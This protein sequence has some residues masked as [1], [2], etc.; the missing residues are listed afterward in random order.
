MPNLFCRFDFSAIIEHISISFSAREAQMFEFQPLTCPIAHFASAKTDTNRRRRPQAIAHRG[1]NAKFPENTLLAFS[2]AV[3][4]NADALE[5]DVHL[6]KDGVVVL[7]HV[8]SCFS[9]RP[10]LVKGPNI[11][12]DPDLK[13]TLG[14]DKQIKQCD[15]EYLKGLKTRREPHEPLARLEDLLKLFRDPG[16]EHI[17]LLLDIKVSKVCREKHGRA[18]LNR[19]QIDDDPPKLMSAVAGVFRRVELGNGRRWQDRVVL[20]YWSVGS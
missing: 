8:S 2:E 3:R 18:K 15:W 6:S 14:V 4:A 16:W 9:E 17:W 1:F 20:A 10:N 19:F 5:T 12:E 7:S 13:R 11:R